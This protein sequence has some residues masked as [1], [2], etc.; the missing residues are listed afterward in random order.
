MTD[1]TS[2]QNALLS[3]LE[4]L[5]PIQLYRLSTAI[6]GLLSDPALSKKVRDSICSG[7]EVTYFSA[8]EN[9]YKRGVVQELGRNHALVRCENESL[10]WRVPFYA[11]CLEEPPIETTG[12]H[13]VSKSTLKVGESV[14]FFTRDKRELYGTVIKLNP[15]TAR[16]LLPTG[17][18]WRVAYSLLFYVLEG[19]VIS[20]RQELTDASLCSDKP[21]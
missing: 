13:K 9:R 20:P 11:L 1:D 10:G 7:Q 8:K 3:G 16:V 2:D 19:E 6:N 12:H 17:Q 18:R 14:G 21:S 5:S 15:T 4:K